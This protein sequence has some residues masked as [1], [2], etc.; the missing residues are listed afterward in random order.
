VSEWLLEADG[1]RKTYAAG[2]HPGIDVVRDVSIS[3]HPGE[4]VGLVGDVGAGKSTVARMLTG[5]LT[6]DYGTVRV[7]G[8]DVAALSRKELLALPGRVHLVPQDLEAILPPRARVAKV[9]EEPLD[10]V[11]T[12]ADQRQPL[13]LAALTAVALPA[14]DVF[15]RRVSSLTADE[16]ARVA[17][18]RALILRPRLVVADELTGALD[19]T[20]AADLVQLMAE[21]GILHGVGYLFVTRDL[22]LAEFLC[23]RLVVIDEGR[24]VDQGPTDQVMSRPLHPRSAELVEAARRQHEP[25]ADAG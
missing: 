5:F 20:A 13:V 25:E 21:L 14:D 18:A 11:K 15:G 6:P 8:T 9:V 7:E 23:D 16:R 22:G 19:P 24:I 4:N 3:I 2:R 17:L 10:W 12:G 1:L